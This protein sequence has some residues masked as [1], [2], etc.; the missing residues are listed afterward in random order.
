MKY[1]DKLKYLCQYQDVIRKIKGLEFER[2]KWHNIGLDIAQKYSDMPPCGG[3]DSK[4]EKSAVGAQ[5]IYETICEEEAAAKILREEIKKAIQTV[6]KARYRQVLEM[7]YINGMT[8]YRIADEYSK[9]EQ[10][11]RKILKNAVCEIEI[12]GC[13]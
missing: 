12:G 10:N 4:V 6:K 13:I 11:I 5:A 3:S 1:E 9:S 2:E 7:R 8:V